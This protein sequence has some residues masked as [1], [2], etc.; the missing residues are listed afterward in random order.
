M[1]CFWCR[2]RN[3]PL[4]NS[5]VR[6]ALQLFTG[7]PE[8]Y[9]DQA[10]RLY[11]QA[12]GQKL[13]RVMGPEAQAL[14]FLHGVIRTDHAIAALDEDGTLLGFAGFKTYSGAFAGGDYNDLRRVYGFWGAAWR[15]TLLSLLERDLENDRFLLDGICVSDLAQGRGVGTALVGAICAEAQARGYSAVRLDVI[16]TNTRARALYERLGFVATKQDKI[17]LLR[18][19]FGFTSSTTMV[20]LLS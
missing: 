8:H 19:V 7:L 6:M 15:G 17:G 10:A 1:V 11:W 12:F 9:R 5:P 4:S 16:D 20:R 13:G 2:P 18:H 14:R 3:P